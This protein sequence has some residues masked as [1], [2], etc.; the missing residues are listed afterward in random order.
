MSNKKK[1]QVVVLIEDCCYCPNANLK[2]VEEEKE[3]YMYCQTATNC[4]QLRNGWGYCPIPN[5]C[6]RL[7][8]K[9]NLCGKRAEVPGILS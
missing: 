1:N 2:F 5:W 9:K 4:I 8:R 3:D 6:P 7:T